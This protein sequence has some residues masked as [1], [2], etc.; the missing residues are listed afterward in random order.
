VALT[1][2]ETLTVAAGTHLLFNFSN[3]DDGDNNHRIFEQRNIWNVIIQT[4]SSESGFE[5]NK[6][7][8]QLS[9]FKTLLV[10]LSTNGMRAKHLSE[11]KVNVKLS[12]CLTKYHTIKTYPVLN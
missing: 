4:R 10:V 2:I 11:V 9:T 8:W 12:L 5:I 3:D 7:K 6:N 1:F